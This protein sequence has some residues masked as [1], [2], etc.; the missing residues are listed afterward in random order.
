[1]QMPAIG[2]REYPEDYAY[3]ATVWMQS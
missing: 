3:I 1:M 2:E